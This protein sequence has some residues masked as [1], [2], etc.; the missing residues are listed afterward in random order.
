ML[1]IRKKL[2]TVFSTTIAAAS[3]FAITSTAQATLALKVNGTQINDGGAGDLNPVTGAITHISINPIAGTLSIESGLSK[4]LIGSASE[5]ELHLD[6]V[7]TSFGATSLTLMLSDT[8]FSG[9]LGD[10]FA[11]LGG[12]FSNPSQSNIT[13]SLY[14]DL[15]NA[16]FGMS[17][18]VCSIGP[19]SGA[20]SFG[21]NCSNTLALDPAY[22]I[23]LVATLNHQGAAHSSF[24]AIAK[25]D[26]RVPEP[27]AMILFVMGL[28]GLAAR[29]RRQFGTLN[30]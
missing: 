17:E 18:L 23:T 16:L 5:P 30:S 1:G 29:R 4:P 7:L 28:V 8:D 20:A 25:D 6:G 2:T 19:L 26:A 15:S 24:N 10:F 27:S 21:G 11:T 22:S 14:R 3:L 13:Y 12:A 9:S